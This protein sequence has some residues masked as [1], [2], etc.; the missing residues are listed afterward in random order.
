MKSLILD[1]NQGPDF[2]MLNAKTPDVK[3]V[4]VYTTFFFIIISFP[5]PE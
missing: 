1:R 3:Y 5:L 2:V 4:K